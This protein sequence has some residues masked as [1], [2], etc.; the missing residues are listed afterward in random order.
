MLISEEEFALPT[1]I[2]SDITTLSGCTLFTSVDI[3]HVKQAERC[4]GWTCA[5]SGAVHNIR[6]PDLASG[7]W[8]SLKCQLSAITFTTGAAWE[9]GNHLWNSTYNHRVLLQ[10]C[11]RL[12]ST[13]KKEK[14]ANSWRK[15]RSYLRDGH[16]RFKCYRGTDSI[17]FIY[18]SVLSITFLLPYFCVF[19]MTFHTTT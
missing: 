11:N 8:T 17:Q 13:P 5:K 19:L 15:R 4:Q 2:I 6:T 12:E 16:E 7:H 9:H 3:L 10:Q 14:I 18:T 1:H